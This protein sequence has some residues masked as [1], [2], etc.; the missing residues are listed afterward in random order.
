MLKK[1]LKKI[2]DEKLIEEGDKIVLGFSGGPDS[3]FLLEALNY[4]RKEINFEFVLAHVNH[5]LR[6]E[7]SDT[8][9]KF[10]IECSER[11]NIPIFV[12]RASIE[13]IAKENNIG[14]EEAGRFIRYEFFEDI[15]KK[16]SSNKIAIAHNL[17]DQIETFLFRLIRG[18]SL[19][20]LEG[21]PN[22]ENIIRP[23]NEVYKSN[24][25]EFLDENKIKYRIDETNF[26]NDFTRNSIRLDLIPW[27]EKRY[28]NNFKDKIFNLIS[29]IKEVNKILE[30]DLKKYEEFRDNRWS[31]NIDL[32]ELEENYIQRKIINEYLKK[33]NLEGSREKIGNIIKLL[34]SNGSKIIKLEKGFI[35]KKQYKNIW[36]EKEKKDKLKKVNKLVT[37][38]IPFKIIFNSY[39][40]E[41]ME[42]NKSFGKNEFLTNLKIGDTI[43]IRM[44]KDGDKIRPLGMESYKKLKDVFINEK[45]PKDVRGEIP[46]I[47]KD[48]EI[49]WASGVK[50]SES[51]KGEE[52]KKGIKL[53][54]RRQ[55]EE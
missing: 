34:N 21:I 10:S 43:E 2:K 5:L 45:V 22:R 53:I 48:D 15:L 28:N 4:A 29:E 18:S 35:L 8:D 55:D 14:L 44:R 1:I 19:E 47:L 24:I 40:V 37:E 17:D 42:D 7:N 41:A 3:V 52:N 6:G 46:L 31:L 16:T 54:I 36:I 9:E 13:E 49:V 23:I 30:I 32:I 51:F 25:L 38:K 26:E 50:K 20:G 39:I 11:L 12:K 27:I 33:Y